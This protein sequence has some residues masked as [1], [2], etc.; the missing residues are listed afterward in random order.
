MYIQKEI[1]ERKEILG[2]M[3]RAI[4]KDNKE[5]LYKFLP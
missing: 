3:E 5:A 1:K 2:E 4:A